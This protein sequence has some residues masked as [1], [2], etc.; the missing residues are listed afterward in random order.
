[1]F[2]GKRAQTKHGILQPTLSYCPPTALRMEIGQLG[3][4]S[5]ASLSLPACNPVKPQHLD[6]SCVL[7]SLNSVC[8]YLLCS[9]TFALVGKIGVK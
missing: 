5:P 2:C 3:S 8:F 9:T 1:M 7:I 4:P 6:F